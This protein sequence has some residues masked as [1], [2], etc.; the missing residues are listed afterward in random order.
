MEIGRGSIF[1]FDVLNYAFYRGGCLS[2]MRAQTSVLTDST[3]SW[4]PSSADGVGELFAT[5][6]LAPVLHPLF[7]DTPS[8]AA[9]STSIQS[10]EHR[11]QIYRNHG[12]KD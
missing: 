7:F 1:R 6:L 8:T 10:A 5:Q 2:E 11:L 12:Q 4:S 9:F 3:P